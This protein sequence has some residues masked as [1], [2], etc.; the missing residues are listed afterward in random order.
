MKILIVE[1]DADT[2]EYMGKLLA[3]RGF[4][5]EISH[6]GYEALSAV[7]SL[8]YDVV[9]L[10]L[11]I[12]YITGLEILKKMRKLNVSVPTI[13]VSG[14]DDINNKVELL[15]AGA[16]DYITKPFDSRDLIARV[17][18]VTR[19]GIGNS[20][21][22]I[23]FGNILIDYSAQSVITEDGAPL[24]LTRKEYIILELLMHRKPSVVSKEVFLSHLYHNICD[25]PNPKIIDVFVCKL[26][27][28]LLETCGDLNTTPKIRT[29]WG[30]GYT[31][32]LDT[33][34]NHEEFKSKQA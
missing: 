15:N 20:S 34:E 6:N 19:R 26:R 14:L 32:Y 31:I 24:Y 22:S 10:D 3:R 8:T 13:A 11:D 27:K 7:K 2:A 23:K 28:K 9:L 33:L 16:D 18:A 17:E 29:V 4:S 30:R 1:D 12:P 21:S 5:C 25:E